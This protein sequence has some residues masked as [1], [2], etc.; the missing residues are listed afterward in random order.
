MFYRQLE[1]YTNAA[2]YV[3]KAANII[4]SMTNERYH[5]ALS[6]AYFELHKAKGNHKKS[7]KLSPGSY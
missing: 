3:E 6:K 5:Y 2:Y 7:P 4:N 1:D